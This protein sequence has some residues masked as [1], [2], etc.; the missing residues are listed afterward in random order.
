MLKIFLVGLLAIFIA[1]ADCNDAS[2]APYDENSYGVWISNSLGDVMIV[3]RNGTYSYCNSDTCEDGRVLLRDNGDV[4]LTDFGSMKTTEVMRS[5]SGW[6]EARQFGPPASYPNVEPLWED[7]HPRDFEFMPTA[8]DEA[9]R[10][11]LCRGLPC[12]WFAG[13]DGQDEY[14]FLKIR[15]Y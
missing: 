9:R 6:D 7:L 15:N 11:R 4:I 12:R 14:V 8:M 13:G 10:N 5:L 1:G 2:S 3:R